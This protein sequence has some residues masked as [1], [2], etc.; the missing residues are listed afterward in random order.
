M[1]QLEE[2]HLEYTQVTDAGLERIAGLTQLRWLDL[3]YTRVT[4]AGLK[5]LKQLVRLA[6]LRLIGTQAAGKGLVHLKELRQLDYLKDAMR[7]M[8]RYRTSWL[9]LNSNICGSAN[10]LP[11]PA[12]KKY[13]RPYPTVRSTPTERE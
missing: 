11:P 9:S 7:A 4:D 2:L 13:M 5:N 3:S 1:T 8:A 6:D 12:C 10:S